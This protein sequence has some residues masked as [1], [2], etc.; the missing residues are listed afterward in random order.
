MTFS[1]E[2]RKKEKKNHPV[3]L[4]T[5]TI[6]S[7]NSLSILIKF[8]LLPKLSYT[9]PLP[10]ESYPSFSKVHRQGPFPDR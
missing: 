6:H 9:S 7:H 3:S 8:K 4:T 1:K 5:S 2:E 10:L